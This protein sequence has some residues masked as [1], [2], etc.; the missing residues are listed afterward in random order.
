[1]CTRVVTH[2]PISTRNEHSMPEPATESLSSGEIA[3]TLQRLDDGQKEVLS[4]L[5]GMRSEFVHRDMYDARETGQDRE[6]REL[7]DGQTLMK[8][9]VEA[10][11]A[12]AVAANATAI[13]AKAAVEGSAPQRTSG[14]TIAGVV[15]SGV[16]GL[17]SLL[18]LLVMLMRYIPN[19]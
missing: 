12:T 11:S 6:I 14:W 16:V 13:A 8:Q 1:M 4:K 9:A 17:G 15:V 10:A 2:A 18:T 7:K 19:Q 5:D 3:R